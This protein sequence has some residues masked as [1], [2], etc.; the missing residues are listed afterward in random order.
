MLKHDYKE[1]LNLDDT[2]KRLTEIKE[3]FMDNNEDDWLIYRKKRN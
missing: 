1:R 2:K 3:V